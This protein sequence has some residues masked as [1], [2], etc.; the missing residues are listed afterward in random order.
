[1]VMIR[2][3]VTSHHPSLTQVFTDDII[4]LYQVIITFYHKVIF[5]I[6][7]IMCNFVTENFRAD[8]TD[9]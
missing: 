5:F 4:V 8:L 9:P 6:D 1:M 3:W 2:G 7:Y